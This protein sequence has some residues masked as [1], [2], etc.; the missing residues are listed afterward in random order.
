MKTFSEPLVKR[1]LICAV[2]G[3]VFGFI[4]FFL[5]ESSNKDDSLW[6]TPTMWGIIF[7]RFL[8]GIV[9]FIAG[10]Y[11]YNKVFKFK[12]MPWLRGSI[13][14]AFVSIDLAIWSLADPTMDRSE[15]W[16]IFGLTILA[17][18]IYGL[19]ID[20][21]SSKIAGQGKKVIEGWSD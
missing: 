3:L 2:L 12:V 6:C 18:A 5:A 1:L 19:I 21:V 15:G 17:G 10:A 16:A 13:L 14:G 11:T 4:C 7:N 20:V 8:L 9:V